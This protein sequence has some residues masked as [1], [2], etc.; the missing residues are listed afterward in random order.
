M[1]NY[2]VWDLDRGGGEIEEQFSRHL[3][4]EAPFHTMCHF[5]LYDEPFYEK[6][7]K[8]TFELCLLCLTDEDKI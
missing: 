7:Y 8:V 4:N 1:F 6:I 3:Y 2:N 5:V